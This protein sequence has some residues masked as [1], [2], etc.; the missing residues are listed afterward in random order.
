MWASE[1]SGDEALL[2]TEPDALEP[3]VASLDTDRARDAAWDALAAGRDAEI[4]SGAAVAVSGP[5]AIIYRSSIQVF[6]TGVPP[7]RSS[8]C[9]SSDET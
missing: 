9:R 6:G 8:R 1:S 7:G 3:V 5:E 2:G 4:E